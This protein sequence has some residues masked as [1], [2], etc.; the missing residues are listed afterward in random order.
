[1]S[2][3]TIIYPA[4]PLPP[5]EPG[6]QKRSL[7]LGVGALVIILVLGATA[8]A[9]N[10]FSRSD[11]PDPTTPVADPV[12]TTRAEPEQTGRDGQMASPVPPTTLAPSRPQP[13]FRAEGGGGD[14]AGVYPARP[15][16]M[17]PPTPALPTKDFSWDKVQISDSAGYINSIQWLG[18]RYLA[19]GN[20]YDEF[21]SSLVAWESTD[22]LNWEE[23][24]L[25]GDFDNANIWQMSFNEF[26]AI[27]IGDSFP[28]V[29]PLL[30][31]DGDVG[32]AEH[33]PY[34]YENSQAVWTTKDGVNWTK[35]SVG[36]ELEA[37]RYF[38]VSAG[39]VGA[40]GFVIIV[41]SEDSYRGTPMELTFGNLTLTI[42]ENR[43]TFA[44]TDASGNEL[45]SG[46]LGEL[47]RWDEN[48]EGQRVWDPETGDVIV[49]VPWEVWEMAYTDAYES[50]G[51]LGGFAYEPYAVTIEYEGWRITLD[52]E[53]HTFTV[54]NIA[55]GDVVV[56][57]DM[58][59][60]WRGPNPKIY[61]DAGDLVLSLTWD[62]LDRAQEE[63]WRTHEDDYQYSQDVFAYASSDGV[64]WAQAEIA[65]S[66]MELGL[67]SIHPR[68]D[69]FIAFGARYDESGGG[70]VVLTSEDGLSWTGEAGIEF[71]GLYF[72]NVQRTADGGFIATGES[73]YGNSVWRSPDGYTWDEALGTRIPEDRDY[74]EWFNQ[75]ATGGLGTIVTGSRERYYDYAEE[76]PEPAT[77]G[78]DGRT[79]TFDDW[80]WPPTVTVTD[81]ASGAVL[82]EFQFEEEGG[83]PEGVTYDNETG[84]TTITDAG[85]TVIFTFTDR[86][87]D[88]AQNARWD[89]P[90]EYGYALP[91][92][93]MYFS[94]DLEDWNEIILDQDVFDGYLGQVT[95]GPNSVVAVFM[96]NIEYAREEA[97]ASSG[98][99]PAF[100]E[101]PP[102]IVVGRPVG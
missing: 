21:Q 80:E 1:M 87:F 96:P 83:I 66:A 10:L 102:T 25:S 99:E 60:L 41:T 47:Y 19:L 76:E 9:V 16:E 17:G 35:W 31:G 46:D 72:W 52:E 93:T 42:D 81:D 20:R 4:Q 90:D 53:S 36:S 61:N 51:P 82:F 91:Q 92:T 18:D 68:G 69:G 14:A 15:R 97:A 8:L 54:E 38:W 58:D 32:V 3:E 28:V 73:T 89:Y 98:I 2:E 56:S 40:P 63:F 84:V 57:G 70:P 88:A 55:T 49:T 7:A 5:D 50:K 23:V 24:E 100:Q 44:I 29:E 77:I 27:A 86:E 37:G 95:V 85:G 67:N 13:Y 34:Y 43:G 65:K 64:D 22:G 39:G 62:E 30:E 26:G 71:Q 79:L 45:A 94:T 78:K 11:A 12:P 33:D 59:S 6:G 75:L 74:A 101:P 48:V